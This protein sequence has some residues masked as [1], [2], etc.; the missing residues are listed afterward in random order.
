[1]KIIIEIIRD[2]YV[3]I[4]LDRHPQKISQNQNK[5]ILPS[6]IQEA[7]EISWQYLPTWTMFDQQ[8]KPLTKNFPMER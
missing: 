3:S 5:K 7:Q 8:Q 2:V 1:M 4:L 6:L